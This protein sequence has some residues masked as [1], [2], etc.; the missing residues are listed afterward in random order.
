M[1]FLFTAEH[2]SPGGRIKMK[3]HFRRSIYARA[4]V[5]VE[6]NSREL[7]EG[8]FPG[9]TV[10]LRTCI[11]SYSRVRDVQAKSREYRNE[12][13]ELIPSRERELRFRAK[14]HC[15]EATTTRGTSVATTTGQRS[16]LIPVASSRHRKR[17][18]T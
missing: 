2:G 12:I 9:T 4:S 3:S 6:A 17:N 18:G 7:C 11:Y 8:R 5:C 1:K 16:F 15:S 14:R 13:S 10:V